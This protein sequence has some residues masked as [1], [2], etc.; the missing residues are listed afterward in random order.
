MLAHAT[1]PLWTQAMRL[2]DIA[3]L[4]DE[5]IKAQLL[6]ALQTALVLSESRE[7]F[8]TAREIFSTE[9]KVLVA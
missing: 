7:A 1:H 8:S 3:L 5:C 2:D 4:I 9:H 6:L